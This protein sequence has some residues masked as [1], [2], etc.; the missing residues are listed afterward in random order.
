MV[1]RWLQFQLLLAPLLLIACGSQPQVGFTP[2]LLPV[3]FS[4]SASGVSVS[5]DKTLVTPIG[6]FSIGAKYSLPDKDADSIYVV[7]RDRRTGDTGFDHTYQVRSGQGEFTAVV[8]GR[9]TVQV[10]D[11]QVLIDVTEGKIE[12][13]ELK[14]V[15]KVAAVKEDNPLVRFVN[16]WTAHWRESIYA[17]FALFS[18]AYDDSTMGEWYGLGFV[19]FLLRL[20]FALLLLVPDLILTGVFAVA[21][22]GYALLGETARNIV[23]GLAVLVGLFLAVAA[24]AVAN[25]W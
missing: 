3:K 8:D 21:G 11:R 19:W 17:P 10:V 6:V 5:G 22:V 7:I 20:L 24:V 18:W 4:I 13:I 15:E 23:Y 1:R 16:N 14:G 25:D 2:A 12:S 9:T